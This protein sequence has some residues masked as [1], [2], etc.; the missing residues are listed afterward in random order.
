MTVINKTQL[1]NL[2]SFQFFVLAFDCLLI[3]YLY[4]PTC[5]PIQIGFCICF[6]FVSI[7]FIQLLVKMRHLQFLLILKLFHAKS[8]HI[9]S[10]LVIIAL[11]FYKFIPDYREIISY[12]SFAVSEILLAAKSVKFFKHEST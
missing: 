2:R 11:L 4:N 7:L 6:L 9:G 10:L 12:V 8:I 5:I 1:N 3:G